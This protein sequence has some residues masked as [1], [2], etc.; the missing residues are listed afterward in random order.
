MK[1]FFIRI[2]NCPIK[3]ENRLTKTHAY[4]AKYKPKGKNMVSVRTARLGTA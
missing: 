1:F 2:G 3:K 4:K